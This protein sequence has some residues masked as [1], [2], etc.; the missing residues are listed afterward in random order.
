MA[1][2]IA[3]YA[4]STLTGS[5]VRV[6]KAS[7]GLRTLAML[8]VSCGAQSSVYPSGGALNTDSA[9]TSPPAPPG[10]FSTTT[11]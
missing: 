11:G 8:N 7:F 5:K 6:S 2:R 10:R 3:G 1:S 4:A 9:P